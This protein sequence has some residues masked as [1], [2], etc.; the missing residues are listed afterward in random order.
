M[1]KFKSLQL[2]SGVEYKKNAKIYIKR[3]K[4]VKECNGKLLIWFSHNVK[5]WLIQKVVRSNVDGG[6]SCGWFF[7]FSSS[8]DVVFVSINSLFCFR[9]ILRKKIYTICGFY[10]NFLLF[11]LLSKLI[12]LKMCFRFASLFYFLGLMKKYTF[13]STYKRKSIFER[14]TG[15]ETIFI[16]FRVVI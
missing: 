16:G 13:L 2:T 1:I 6:N 7:S 15:A 3:K 11:S 5:A 10:F 8:S 4:N 12:I 14:P 9:F